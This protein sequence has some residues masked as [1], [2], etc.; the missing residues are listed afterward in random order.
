MLIPERIKLNLFLVV[1]ILLNVKCFVFSKCPTENGEC[2]KKYQPSWESLDSRPLP[3]WY[4]NAKVGIFVHWGVYTVPSFGSEW[5][6]INWKTGKK[7]YVDF[8]EKNYAPGFTYQEFAHDFKAELFN[9]TQWAKLFKDSGA[10]YV[11]LTSKHHD[12]FCLWPSSRSFSWNSMDIGPKKD[13]IREW[14]SF[15]HLNLIEKLLPQNS[16][17]LLFVGRDSFLVF[18]ILFLNGSTECTLKT[19]V[20][21][22]SKIIT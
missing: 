13:I 19:R 20:M 10:Q 6:W 11:V 1:F 9:A 4:D 8:M 22:S 18:T 7:S 3:Q 16:S 12:G 21:S 14:F 17:R 15:L 2:P 5:F